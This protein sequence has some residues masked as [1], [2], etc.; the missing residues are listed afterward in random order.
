MA[1]RLQ[2][3]LE[4]GEAQQVVDYPVGKQYQDLADRIVQ[5]I[6]VE[7]NTDNHDHASTAS[8]RTAASASSPSTSSLPSLVGDELLLPH[9]DS[10]PDFHS[11]L[12]DNSQ[13]SPTLTSVP[14]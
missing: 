9:G 4:T 1:A 6:Q 2:R 3:M 14:N 5:R 13:S 10:D 12:S 7:S 8:T 11:I